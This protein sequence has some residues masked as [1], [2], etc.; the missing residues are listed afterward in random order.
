MTTQQ[1]LA[2]AQKRADELQQLADT[3]ALL[4]NEKNGEIDRLNAALAHAQRNDYADDLEADC[5]AGLMAVHP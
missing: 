5:E 1:A 4:I 3:Q 2:L